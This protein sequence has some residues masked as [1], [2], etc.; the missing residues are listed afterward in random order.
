MDIVKELD[1]LEDKYYGDWEEDKAALIDALR[2]IHLKAREN[3]DTFNR[4]LVQTA[5]RFGG[6]YIPF[7]FWEKIS[8]FL[9]APEE[10]VY[11][12][13]LIRIFISSNFEEEEQM[14]MKPLLVTY[15]AKEKEFELGK[16][17][18]LVVDK[19]HPS[20]KDYFYKLMSFVEKN[21]RATEMYTE[22]F[23]LLKHVHPDFDLLS[24]PITQLKE[25]LEGAY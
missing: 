5:E 21:Q 20:V 22:K 11:I 14:H 18:A 6:A 10:R 25:K 2:P 17:R 4:F 19:S 9:D 16:I 7:L 13:E 24:M 12:H 1:Q 3:K 8:D 15:F 23:M